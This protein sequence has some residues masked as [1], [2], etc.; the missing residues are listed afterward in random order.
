MQ[1]YLTNIVLFTRYSPYTA[2]ALGN[3]HSNDHCSALNIGPVRAGCRSTGPAEKRRLINP[4]ITVSENE[5]T[6][7]LLKSLS[8]PRDVKISAS[9]L[10]FL[11]SASVSAS[12]YAEPRNSVSVTEL[13]EVKLYSEVTKHRQSIL[14]LLSRL[15]T[16]RPGGAILCS[17]RY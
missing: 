14:L 11:A 8:Q 2:H 5:I 12:R 7:A 10:W 4:S 6:A 9:A 13:G 15:F 1:Y 17:M 3:K 16:V